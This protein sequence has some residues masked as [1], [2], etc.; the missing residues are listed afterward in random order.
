M[1]EKQK[2]ILSLFHGTDIRFIH[3]LLI[4]QDRQYNNCRIKLPGCH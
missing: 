3:G 1:N 2:G 4:K